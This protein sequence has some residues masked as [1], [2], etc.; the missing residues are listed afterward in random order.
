VAEDFDEE[1]CRE[2]VELEIRERVLVICS[3]TANAE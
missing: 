1:F 2:L 3:R